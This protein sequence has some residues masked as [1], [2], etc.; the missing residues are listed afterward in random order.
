MTKLDERCKMLPVGHQLT[1]K[2]TDIEMERISMLEFPLLKSLHGQHSS[3]TQAVDDDKVICLTEGGVYQLHHLGWLE[4]LGNLEA[5]ALNRSWIE[6]FAKALEI[7]IGK[8]KGL[9]I[10]G[11]DEDMRK[12]SMRDQ[13]K[14]LIEK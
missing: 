14:N 5:S 6:I 8:V 12:G 4:S 9:R 2:Q 3:Q 1:K 7:Y 10:V 11:V 13:L